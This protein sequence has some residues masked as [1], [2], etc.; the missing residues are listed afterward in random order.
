MIRSFITVLC[1][2][3]SCCA[4][5]AQNNYPIPEKTPNQLFYI[6]HSNNHNTYVYDYN[7][8]NGVIDPKN[9]IHEYRIS[10]TEGGERQELST[11][12]RKM[13]YGMTLLNT[14]PN[15]LTFRLAATD[16]VLLYLERNKNGKPKVYVTLNDCKIYLDKMFVQ[17]KEGLFKTNIE[18]DYILFYGSGTNNKEQI[19]ERLEID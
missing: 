4:A 10:Y 9:P 16:K 19:I 2:F 5:T 7:S 8:K 12:Q 15:I 1:I 3:F 13:A 17:L 14:T 6:Q 18:V 11:I